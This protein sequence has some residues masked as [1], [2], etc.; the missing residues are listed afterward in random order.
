MLRKARRP[1]DLQKRW[2]GHSSLATGDRYNH[3]SEEI[4][5]RRAALSHVGLD[6]IVR[7]NGPKPDAE[8]DRADEALKAIA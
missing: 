6:R 7:P 2:L 4:E 8:V 3:A 1:E 5:Y